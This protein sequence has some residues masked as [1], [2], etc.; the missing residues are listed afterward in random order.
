MCR[1]RPAIGQ[2][3]DLALNARTTEIIFITA[4]YV[5]KNRLQKARFD[6]EL[7]KAMLITMYSRKLLHN[8]SLIDYT[9]HQRLLMSLASEYNDF[10]N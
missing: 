10:K 9:T 6:L 2:T 4:L 3:G 1:Y 5:Y 8:A 7:T